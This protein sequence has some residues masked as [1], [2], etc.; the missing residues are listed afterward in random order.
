MDAKY[1]PRDAKR[2][3]EWE[4]LSLKQE[5]L[6]AMEYAAKFNELSQFARH[7]VPT[8]EMKMDRFEQGPKGSI[9]SM[10]AGHSFKNFR[11]MYQRAIKITRVL[12]ETMWENRTSNLGKRKIDYN[13]RGPRGVNPKRFNI[14]GPQDKGKQ[15][16]P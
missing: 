12:E 5:N 7:Q 8:E 13:N 11:E 16:M 9:K 15:P 10:V 4:F 6:S 2:A 1:Y 14:G 3:K